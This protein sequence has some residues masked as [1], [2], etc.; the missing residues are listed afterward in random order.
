MLHGMDAPTGRMAIV[1]MTPS[2]ESVR[3]TLVK[4]ELPQLETIPLNVTGSFGS[5]HSG[6]QFLV[7]A[8]HGRVSI[9]QV[10]VA[11]VDANG[12]E[13]GSVKEV[14]GD[15]FL[16]ARS[17]QRDVYVPLRD[18]AAVSE[19]RVTLTLLTNDVSSLNLETP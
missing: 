10:R 14:R 11:V 19:G 6:M 2:K 18:V 3:T 5:R 7:T 17:M 16:L 8:T 4:V 9:G 1:L 15:D 13:L 12:I